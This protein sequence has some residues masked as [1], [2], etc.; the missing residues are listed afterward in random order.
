MMISF[1]SAQALAFGTML[2]IWLFAQCCKFL[3]NKWPFLKKV[4]NNFHFLLI[5][6]YYPLTLL[7]A[8][9][10]YNYKDFWLLILLT[11]FCIGIF[12]VGVMLFCA[13]KILNDLFKDRS[14]FKTSAH[15]FI[16]DPFYNQYRDDPN[17]PELKITV[18]GFLYSRC[19]MISFELS[20][21]EWRS[22]AA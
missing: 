5:L 22:K 13:F 12:S 18:S 9:Q 7:A 1:F 8:Y 16:Y 4:T 20:L 2:F 10:I 11:A 14:A 17:N 15:T 6:F 19:L 21:Q 3:R